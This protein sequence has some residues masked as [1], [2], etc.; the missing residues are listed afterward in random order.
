MSKPCTVG[1]EWTDLLI[2]KSVCGCLSRC[3]LTSLTRRIDAAP[4]RWPAVMSSMLSPT[5]IA[6][7][8]L[9]R[10]VAFSP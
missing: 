8:E 7:A 4:A 9:A 5:W 3:A 1:G 6:L 10:L 2:Q